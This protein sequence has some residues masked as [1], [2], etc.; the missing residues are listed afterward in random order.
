MDL[1]FDL[2]S[3]EI[4]YSRIGRIYLSSK[5]KK[6][7]STPNIIIPL[8]N[9]LIS[10]INFL[11]YFETHEIFFIT[12]Q[13]FLK[14]GFLRE[15]FKNTSFIYS[16]SGTIEKFKAILKKNLQIFSQDN[17]I[18]IIPFNI[19]TTSIHKD[20]AYDEIKRYLQDV[21]DI[22]DLYPEISFG[23]TVKLFDYSELIE[24]YIQLIEEKQNI[25]I[26]NIAD[27][28]DTLKNYRSTLRVI[29]KI[30]NELDNNLV[31][32]ASGRLIPKFYPLLVYLG[33]DLID[34]SYMMFISA[35]NF[36]NT[37]ED[38]LPIYKLKDLPCPC[39][40]CSGK[41]NKILQKKYSQEKTL[42]LTLHNLISAKSYMNKIKQYLNTEDYRTF[43]EKTIHDD[44]LLYSSLR[45]LDKDYYEN[46]RL[47]TPISSKIPSIRCIGPASYYRPDFR[48][49]RDRVVSNFVPEDWSKLILILP[50][51]ARKPYSESKSHK[52]FY[53]IIRKFPEFPDFQEF[54]LTSPLGAIPRQLENI[55]PVT[56]YDI[57]VT[58]DWDYE[59]IQLAGQMLIKLIKKYDNTIPIICHLRGGYLS[60][61]KE[62][63]KN[64]EHKFYFTNV[65]ENLTSEKALNSLEKLIKA[66][67]N[68]SYGNVTQKA[69][70][71]DTW[72]RKFRKIADYQYGV[73]SGVKLFTNGISIRQN[74]AK[75]KIRIFKQKKNTLI[76]TFDLNRGQIELTIAGAE[77]LFPFDKNINYLVFDGEKVKGSNLF[78]PGVIE[79]SPK[80]LPRNNVIIVNKTMQ[81]IIAVGNAVIGS[82]MIKNIKRGIVAEVY[83]KR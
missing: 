46:I 30:K 64:V 11:E 29:D 34:S 25:K 63:I 36:Y 50:C 21:A 41:L 37:T 65:D 48:T 27:L 13:I 54:I 32:M 49:F 68:N 15:K 28:F 26:L 7:F 52:E 67:I 58:G 44:P 79:F 39:I 53:K 57:P 35:E 76:A 51:S 66:L 43:L 70:V 6:Y 42:L 47:E 23:I 38:L 22:L 83:E 61:I 40:V 12:K 24:L 4:G 9:T 82:N 71:T 10:N 17:V 81:K 18:S 2:K 62:V 31:L 77:L 45:I 59:E 16:H 60:I 5:D 33:F 74:R 20:F 3:K 1:F 75:T 19:P 56:S 73:G 14:I 55:Y 78:K 72:T 69:S 8:T 80:I